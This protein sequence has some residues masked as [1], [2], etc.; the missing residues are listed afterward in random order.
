LRTLLGSFLLLT[1][2]M[3]VI[4]FS[5]SLFSTGRLFKRYRQRRIRAYVSKCKKMSQFTS[6]QS[7]F[8]RK[9]VHF[10]FRPC[11]KKGHL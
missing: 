7:T 4:V 2:R 5:D 9:S 8:K 3:L 11:S 10:L 6:K 1:E